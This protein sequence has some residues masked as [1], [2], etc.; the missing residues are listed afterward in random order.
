[1]TRRRRSSNSLPG[2]RL[3]IMPDSSEIGALPALRQAEAATLASGGPSLALALGGGG[4]RGLSHILILEALDE[5]GIQP[6]A[7]AGTSIGALVGAAYAAGMSGAEIRAHCSELFQKRTELIKRFISRWNG[8]FTDILGAVTL[9]I[10]GADRLVQALLPPALP[11]G[12][13]G[14]VI[15]LTVVT[16]DFYAQDQQIITEGALFP[17]ITASSALP[18]V[19][20]PV[21]I[22]GR[23][24]ID[25]GFV[26]PL[27]FD[28][29]TG[30]ADIIAAVDVSA[31][32]PE[33]RG[34]T[35][36]FFETLIGAMQISLRSI[37]QEKLRAGAPDILIRP[38]VG[39]YR[40]LDFFKF[41]EILAASAD[42]KDEFKRALHA[43]IE[44]MTQPSA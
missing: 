1:M 12:F 8:K 14:L 27:P 32:A 30:T 16:T 28:L 38:N 18:T 11:A 42:C 29:L 5:L 39:P 44:A 35:P 23:L 7:I 4:A 9:P 33:S 3:A 31:G 25:G 20:K 37:I 13:D 40:V 22:D 21:E 2:E 17:A 41:E 6:R 19:F 10:T 34:K 26:N 43:R 36:A 15:P 24:L